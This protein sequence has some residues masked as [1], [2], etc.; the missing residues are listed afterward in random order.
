MMGQ[1]M[2]NWNTP[3]PCQP[4]PERKSDQ[5]NPR[6]GALYE[7]AKAV[8]DLLESLGV[9]WDDENLQGTPL[10]VAKAWHNDLLRGE[11]MSE[12][13]ALSTVF[14]S[15]NNQMVLL[16]DI[17]F[18]STCSHHLIPFFGKA[19]VAYIPDGRVVGLSK[20]ARVVEVFSR[21][22]QLQ[23]RMTDQ[24]ADA[25]FDVL[26][27]K[28]VGVI[29]QGKHLCMAARGVAKQN[30]SMVTSALRGVFEQPATRNEFMALTR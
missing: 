9:D 19:H 18:Y 8:W 27:P 16:R 11:R 29:V 17:E 26:Q 14:T 15:T 1:D 23:E 20:L 25:V 4:P 5:D 6:D 13:D 28:G 22:L 30:A 2:H 7:P 21:R 10:R 24:I 12:R 3:H